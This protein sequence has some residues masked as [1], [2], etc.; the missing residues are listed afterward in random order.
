MT[1][2]AQETQGSVSSFMRV[3]SRLP[4]DLGS[5]G[6]SVVRRN[7]GVH[8]PPDDRRPRPGRW[9]RLNLDTPQHAAASRQ[10]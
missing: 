10:D 6:S 3:V 9:N 4:T 1:R 8:R 2:H 7:P 5:D